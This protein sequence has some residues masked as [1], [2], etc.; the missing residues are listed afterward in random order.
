MLKPK[1][2]DLLIWVEQGKK[3]AGKDCSVDDVL[4]MT[5]DH[6]I[7]QFV[8]RQ[9]DAPKPY[10]MVDGK[11]NIQ[12]L[13]ERCHRLK[14]Y[15]DDLAYMRRGRKVKETKIPKQNKRVMPYSFENVQKMFKIQVW[16]D[17]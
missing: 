4:L 11:T 6:I 8:L 9:K 3:C 12:L 5:R 7:P 2:S 16:K 15:E 1:Q 14:T 17:E 13:C 10:T